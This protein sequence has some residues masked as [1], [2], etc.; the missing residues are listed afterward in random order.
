MLDHDTA[1]TVRNLVRLGRWDDERIAR[2]CGID[3]A[4]VARARQ[5]VPKG[6]KPS[7]AIY[8]N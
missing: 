2:Y 3:A 4:A 7:R 8:E 6:R 1:E 5:L